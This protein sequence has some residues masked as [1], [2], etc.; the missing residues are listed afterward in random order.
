ME[1]R[2]LNALNTL[3]QRYPALEVCRD[4]I[5]NAFEI[6]KDSYENGGKLMICG[7]GGSCAD[8]QHIV[9]ELMKSFTIKRN[10]TPKDREA[11]ISLY[12]E[13]GQF[14][15]D[16]LEKGLP[17]ISLESMAGISTAFNNDVEP[18]LVYAQL[19]YNCGKAGDVLLGISTSGNSKNV[20]YALKLA[21][22]M[23]IKTIGLT[24]QNGGV[25]NYSC[26]CVI[27]APSLV[28]YQIQEYHLP[29]YHALC[30]M[31]E[32]HFFGNAE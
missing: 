21:K 20:N 14:M 25:F 31:L 17:A 10:T 29:I 28:T 16:R 24:G 5:L 30:I 13:D 3:N 1:N 32:E 22:A 8:S 23:G 27:H 9:G 4:E 6:V 7:N 19:A 18:V 11:L 15:A 26:D 2:V 12:G